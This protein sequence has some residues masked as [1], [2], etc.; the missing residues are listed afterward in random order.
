[1]KPIF[2]KLNS[3][4]KD[5][6]QQYDTLIFQLYNI[7]LGKYLGQLGKTQHMHLE[8]YETVDIIYTRNFNEIL[9]SQRLL[10]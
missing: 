5:T 6:L 3:N 1:M 7:S 8:L 10:K 4:I 9:K 2:S